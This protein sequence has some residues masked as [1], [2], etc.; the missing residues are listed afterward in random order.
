MSRLRAL[1]EELRELR[2]VLVLG[3]GGMKGLV[4]VGVLRALARLGIPVHEVANDQVRD[5]VV[6]ERDE[7]AAWAIERVG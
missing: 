4:H 2:S 1:A 5:I 3:G 7:V 6:L